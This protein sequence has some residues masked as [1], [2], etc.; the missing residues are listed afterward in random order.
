MKKF[1]D[2]PLIYRILALIFAILLFVYVNSSQVGV[3]DTQNNQNE[4]AK[5]ATRSE[6]ITMPLQISVNTDTYFVTGYPEQVK[7][8]LEGPTALIASTINT[9]NFRVFVDLSKYKVGSHTVPIEI[10]GLNKQITYTVKPKVVNVK[11]QTRKSKTFPIQVVYNKE[12]VADGYE[13]G[14]PKSDPSVV[15]VTGPRSEVNQ[16]D[17]IEARLTVPKGSN[18][19]LE[20]EL[21]LVAVDKNGN[22]MNVVMSPAT[23]HITLPISI[24]SKTLKL[25]VVQKNGVSDLDYVVKTKISSVQVYGAEDI[26]ADLDELEVEVDLTDQ[27]KDFEKTIELKKPKGVI[28]IDPEVVT[29]AV[30]VGVNNEKGN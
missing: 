2:N 1:F 28:R 7:V 16:V 3:V 24:P 23:S 18:K 27:E 4:V 29:V 17:H 19:T 15:S 11:I 10:S 21:M 26:L 13:T 14:V 12:S 8:T 30:K 5:T 20:Q 6:T 22:Q 9:K 25:K